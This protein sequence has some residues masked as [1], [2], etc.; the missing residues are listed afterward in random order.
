MKRIL[1]CTVMLMGLVLL[2]QGQS[3]ESYIAAEPVFLYSD[4]VIIGR[5]WDD[6]KYM[7]YNPKTKEY[8]YGDD[9]PY[10]PRTQIVFGYTNYDRVIVEKYVVPGGRWGKWAYPKNYVIYYTSDGSKIMEVKLGGR[11][12]RLWGD[13]RKHYE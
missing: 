4:E 9:D 5:F 1:L 3:H 10:L 13:F 2:L 8:E 12:Y 11:L 6:A 7:R